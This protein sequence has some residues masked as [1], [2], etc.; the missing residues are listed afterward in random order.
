MKA[1]YVDGV[2]VLF[3]GARRRCVSRLEDGELTG[4]TLSTELEDAEEPDP[5]MLA[6]LAPLGD[7]VVVGDYQ[8]EYPLTGDALA[9][10]IAVEET[11]VD[12][13]FREAGWI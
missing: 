8:G 3:P 9:R 11:V 1:V 2:P 6:V 4:P 7:R 5:D 12:P 10:S 13:L